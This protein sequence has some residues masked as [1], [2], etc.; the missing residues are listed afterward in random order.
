MTKT[1]AQLN[2]QIEQLKRQADALRQKEVA[3]VIT[4][5]KNAIDHYGLTV[6]DLGFGTANTPRKNARKNTAP[7]RTPLGKK[8]L[9]VAA[10]PKAAKKTIGVIRYRDEAGNTWTGHGKRPNWFKAALAAGK[11]LD[12]LKVPNASK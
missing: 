4:R 1:L 6:E 12:A 10:S 2:K 11:E 7:N 8:K 3:D 9:K 5:I